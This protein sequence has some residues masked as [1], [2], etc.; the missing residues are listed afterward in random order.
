MHKYLIKSK[1]TSDITI[2]KFE[3]DRFLVQNQKFTFHNKAEARES[4]AAQMLFSLAYVKTVFIAQNFIAVKISDNNKWK[5]AENEILKLIKNFLNSGKNVVHS[6]LPHKIPVTL[7]MEATPNPG[8]MKFVAHKKLVIKKVKFER[9]ESVEDSPLSRELFKFPYVEA[10]EFENNFLA[11]RKS[12]NADW[13]EI[14]MELREFIR[15]YLMKCKPVI[16]SELPLS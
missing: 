16:N 9:G 4:P 13:N 8:V 14:S 7:Y 15:T 11:I 2:R 1:Q 10:I 3:T 6:V 5:E 12:K